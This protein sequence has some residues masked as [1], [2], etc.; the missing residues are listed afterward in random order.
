MPWFILF[1]MM[2]G[3]AEKRAKE[4]ADQNAVAEDMDEQSKQQM[5]QL[6]MMNYVPGFDTYNRSIHGGYL[7]DVQFYTETKVP[8]SRRGL[9]NGLAQQILHEKMV[10]M[11]YQ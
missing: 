11:Q 4:I 9:R 10:E 3:P 2:Q 1:V 7:P 5:E 8:E 6:A